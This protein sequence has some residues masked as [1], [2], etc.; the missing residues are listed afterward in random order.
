[1]KKTGM[2]LMYLAI[3][4]AAATAMTAGIV[5]TAKSREAREAD[6]D[7]EEEEET[8]EEGEEAEET[9]EEESG[10]GS[11]PGFLTGAEEQYYTYLKETYGTGESDLVSAYVMD[12]D[13]DGKKD[14]LTVT[15]GSVILANT[16]LGPFGIYDGSLN[17]ATLDLT[18]YQANGSSVEKTGAILG[19]GTIEGKSQ[20]DMSISIVLQDEKPYI[21]GMSENEDEITYGARPYVVYEVI[22]GGGF[23]YDYVE[24]IGWGQSSMGTTDNK[25]PNQIAGTYNLDVNG[26]QLSERGKYGVVLCEAK[27]DNIKNPGVIEATDYTHVKEGMEQ[28]YAAISSQLDAMYQEMVQDAEAYAGG[29]EKAKDSEVLFESFANELSAAGVNPVLKE[30]TTDGDV[31]KASYTCQEVDLNVSINSTT[32]SPVSISLMADGYPVAESWYPVKDAV[33][34]SAF[35]GLDQAKIASLLGRTPSNLS[36]SQFDAGPAQILAGNTDTIIMR[37]EYR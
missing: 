32:G 7:E 10:E 29:Q 2:V 33:L 23:Q 17:A 18:M 6:K 20:G 27:A 9:A 28:G 16:P 35:A 14:L 15:K 21:C 22:D 5:V 1:M 34:Q 8:K 4:A 13:G 3:T 30:F 31:I 26:T 37:I 11:V 24:G 25:D 12:F 19:A 36:V